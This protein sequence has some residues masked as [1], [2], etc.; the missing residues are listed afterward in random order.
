VENQRAMKQVGLAK[1]LY[2]FVNIVMK[3]LLAFS[4]LLFSGSA[5]AYATEQ[6][7]NPGI[8]HYY[9]GAGYQQ[10]FA[11]FER[12]GREVFDRRLDVVQALELKPAMDIADI[13]A[14]T[15]FYSLLFAQQVGSSGNVY[16]VDITDDFVRNIKRR[17]AE[18]N[19]N[20]IHAIVNS[21]KD[22]GLPA[23]S[24][25]MAFVCNT[26]HHFEYPQTMLA[27]IYRALRPGGKLV[28][29]DYRKQP[30]RS[31]AWVMSHV[32][33]AKQTVI[34]E[35]QQAGF[36]LDSESDLLRENYFLNFVK[37]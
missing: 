32:R 1:I 30:G 27:S 10:W 19:L 37:Q 17:A 31:S 23:H 18:Q 5:L 21:H 26:Y 6:N 2:L 7:V 34:Y 3:P 29:I 13:G 11:T 35:I 16:A 33:S 28:I 15:G 14:G 36:K 25:D 8:N 24:I 9:Q 4:W 12:P 22:T 20:N